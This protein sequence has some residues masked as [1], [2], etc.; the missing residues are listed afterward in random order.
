MEY[1]LLIGWDNCQSRYRDTES[2]TLCGFVSCTCVD[3]CVH[4]KPVFALAKPL[5]GLSVYTKC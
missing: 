1:L 3:F 5:N 4:V 2:K